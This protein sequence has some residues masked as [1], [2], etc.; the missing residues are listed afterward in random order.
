MPSPPADKR[1]ALLLRAGA[2]AAL[3][4][5]V[6]AGYRLFVSR[7]PAPLVVY[8]AHDSIYADTILRA[9]EARTGIPVAVRYDTEATKSLG[10]VEMLLQEKTAPQCDVFWNNEVL[11]TLRLQ[12]NGVLHPYKGPGFDRIPAS[13]K[14]PDGYWVGFAARLRVWI[15]N[16]DRLGPSQEA[17]DGLLTGRL[18]RVAIAKPLY[19]TTFTHYCALWNL[20]G[21]QKLKSWHRDCRARGMREVAGNAQVRSVVAEGTCDL[22]YTDSDDFFVAKDDGKPVTMLPMRLEDGRTI[23]MPNTVSIIEGTRRPAEAGRLVDFLLSQETEVAL[24][25]AKSRQ[26]PL[27]PVNEADLPEEVVR[28]KAW[29]AEGY[30]LSSLASASEACLAWLK[31]EYVQ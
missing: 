18:D 10:L 20:W 19:G 12:K 30:P 4:V 23:C 29:A 5:A 31:A 14:D 25:R 8:C 24:A 26:I 22:G 7:G 3:V 15:I 1:R 28:M 2:V 9:F 13:F 27:G 6:A 16:T 21:E 17:L 11:G